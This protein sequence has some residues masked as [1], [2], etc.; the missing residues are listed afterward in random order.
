MCPLACVNTARF[1]QEGTPNKS[2][3]WGMAPCSVCQYPPPLGGADSTNTTE[4]STPQHQSCIMESTAVFASTRPPRGRADSTNTARV[5]WCNHQG[6]LYPSVWL[7]EEES[8]SLFP[9]ARMVETTEEDSPQRP[10]P[11]Y[12]E[13]RMVKTPE[14]VFREDLGT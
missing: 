12:P 6:D 2:W 4:G 10:T 5:P 7:G 13:A 1:P 9:E 11:P 14:W 3:C 8:S